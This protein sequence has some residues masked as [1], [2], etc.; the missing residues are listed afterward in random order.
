MIDRFLSQRASNS[1]TFPSLWMFVWYKGRVIFMMYKI[2]IHSMLLVC[3]WWKLTIFRGQ[4]N[5]QIQ[6]TYISRSM[7][8]FVVGWLL[9]LYHSL[10]C[11]LCETE[12][13]PRVCEIIL[14]LYSL[15]RYRLIGM[16]I[17]II[18]LRRS[19]D[20]LRFIMGIHIPVRRRPFVKVLKI[21]GKWDFGQTQQSINS[22]HSSLG[23]IVSPW[24]IIS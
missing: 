23:V 15:S 19:S 18:N 17:P 13:F 24:N 7:H 11:I 9:L 4:E 6:F 1:E 5:V 2:P 14:G 22:V 16:Q 8:S 10:L 21:I 20:S 3:V 12:W